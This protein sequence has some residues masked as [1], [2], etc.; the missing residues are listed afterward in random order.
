[1]ISRR[2]FVLGTGALVL[3]GAGVTAGE[4]ATRPYDRF[5][6][7]QMLGLV[8][9]PDYVP[10][11][12]G[13]LQISGEL[14]SRFTHQ[15]MG[16]TISTPAHGVRPA[17]VI[18]CLHAKGGN[19]RMAFDDI[20]VPDMAAAAGLHVAVAAVDGVADSYWHKRADGTDALSMLLGEFVPLVERRIGELP[21][22]LM[23]WSMGGYGAL[24]AA[25]RAAGQFKAVAP[26][27]PALWT[28]PGATA[29]GAFDSPADYYANDVFS[30]VARLKG[31][32]VAIG[33]GES[34]PF[35][36]ATRRLVSLMDFPHQTFFGPGFHTG[37][38]WRSI[39]RQQLKA[40]APAL[41]L[42]PT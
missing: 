13:A 9:G 17:A 29:P 35:Y 14:S 40:M 16:W 41:G 25:E 36:A 8:S 31:M 26:A 7:E 33:C 18:F 23:G 4:L 30:G 21:K 38:F 20:Q 1:V 15:S 42:N 6:V 5:R 10:A 2:R 12:S 11:P 3:A 19:H 27:G 39:A 32:G 24:L 28:S 37:G 34:D 22:A